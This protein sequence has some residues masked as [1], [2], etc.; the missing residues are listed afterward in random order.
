MVHAVVSARVRLCDYEPWDVPRLSSTLRKLRPEASTFTKSAISRDQT[1]RIHVAHTCT[2]L[3]VDSNHTR[4]IIHVHMYERAEVEVHRDERG[5]LLSQ[6]MT[7]SSRDSGQASQM[8]LIAALPYETRAPRMLSALFTAPDFDSGVTYG[9]RRFMRLSLHRGLTESLV[10]LPFL[11]DQKKKR[12]GMGGI[13]P[14]EPL[15]DTWIKDRVQ[16]C[17]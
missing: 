3:M 6:C 2:L 17:E 1:S 14:S 16:V 11:L 8:V 12:Q 15:D 13:E 9:R 4:N 7:E 10:S 5:V